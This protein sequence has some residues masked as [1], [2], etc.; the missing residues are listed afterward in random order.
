M[1]GDDARLAR[2][3]AGVGWGQ[4]MEWRDMRAADCPRVDGGGC[5]LED[6]DGGMCAPSIDRTWVRCEDCIARPRGGRDWRRRRDAGFDDCQ[7][8]GT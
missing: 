2:N 4:A 3:E 8:G 6:E 5:G 7:Q 1:R